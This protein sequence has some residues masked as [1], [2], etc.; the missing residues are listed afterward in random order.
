MSRKRNLN[1]GSCR[2]GC[3]QKNKTMLMRKNHAAPSRCQP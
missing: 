1:A 3:L 2:L